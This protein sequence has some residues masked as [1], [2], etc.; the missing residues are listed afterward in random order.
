MSDEHN[1]F[2]CSDWHLGHQKMVDLGHRPP[3][4]EGMISEHL[5][6]AGMR[7]GDVL[8][9]LGDVYLYHAGEEMLGG[10]LAWTREQG[11]S[12]VLVR[13][14]HDSSRLGRALRS[15]W[16]WV[17]DSTS[18]ECYG[19]KFL[20]THVPVETDFQEDF[21][22][23]GHLHQVDGHRGGLIRDGKHILISM[24]L[25]RYRPIPLTRLAEIR[26]TPVYVLGKFAKESDVGNSDG[27]RNSE[28]PEETR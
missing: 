13:G 26:E 17:C 22:V 5:R 2:V 28:A 6:G 20:F 9:N 14:N 8:L 23:H 3:G 7:R 11:I 19:K 16:S 12:T 4:F 1:I 21:N 18:L 24:E 15:G 10:I 27:P 25:M